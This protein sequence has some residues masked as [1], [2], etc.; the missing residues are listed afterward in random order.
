MTD[1][2]TSPPPWSS[3]PFGPA[4]LA[5]VL[6][7]FEEPD[8]HY[9]TDQPDTRS[10]AE[11]VA[12]LGDD[13]RV[14]LAGGRVVGLYALSPDGAE[15]GGGFLLTLRLSRAVPES[16]W[17]AAYAEVELAGHWHHEIV[18]LSTRFASHDARG[19]RVARRLPLVEEGVL[20]EVTARDGDRF[21]QVFFARVWS[22]AG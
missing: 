22:P 1:P 17:A 18:R 11:I 21:G 19:L 9:R 4:D 8:F 13:T 7:L 10:T 16:W 12:L 5:A 6:A 3:R 2:H 20:A 14:L 15:H